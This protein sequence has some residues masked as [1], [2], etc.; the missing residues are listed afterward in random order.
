M[1]GPPTDVPAS[2]LFQRLSQRLPSEVVAFPRRTPDGKPVG[3]LRIQV[4]PIDQINHARA[5]GINKARERYKLDREDR[6]STYGQGLVSDCILAEVL[7]ACCRS[8]AN[9]GNDEKEFY[10]LIFQSA[11]QVNET[12]SP[13]EMGTL[14]NLYL[15]VQA[16]Y[17]PSEK[18]IQTEEELSA[19][20]KRLVEGAAEFPLQQLS[21]V[22]WDD[23]ASLLAQRA[24]T[25]SVILES[26]CESLPS[27]FRS[28][29]AT[30]SLGTGYFGSPAPSTSADGTETSLSL[31]IPDW[32]ISREDAVAMTERMKLAEER[33]MAVLLP[34]I[35]E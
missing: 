18:T 10:P 19:W 15:Q 3:K 30:F 7:A 28:R 14:Y 31:R 26:L 6:E 1:P 32:E 24:Y 8:E 23:V 25:L 27:S 29:L 13:D 11:D 5:R 21:S 17:G 16:K 12:L 20:I 33:L 9:H 22:H 4:L 35:E 2:E 34:T